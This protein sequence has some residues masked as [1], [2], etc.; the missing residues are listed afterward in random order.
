MMNTPSRI[1]SRVYECRWAEEGPP[2][3]ADLGTEFWEAAQWQAISTQWNGEAVDP[4]WE[5]SFAARWTEDF[6]YF[7]FHSRFQNLTMVDRPLVQTRTPSLWDKE[8]VVEIFIA[9]DLKRP[10]RY[11][12]FELSPSA[13]WIEIDLDWDRNLKNFNW[14]AGMESRST[15]NMVR[16]QWQ[17]EFRVPLG[18][19]EMKGVA[20]GTCVALNA[21]RVELRSCLYLAWNPTMTPKPDFHV[22]QRF[23]QMF[24][25]Q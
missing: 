25:S 11:K 8:D 15:V 13:Q 10:N 24:L 14:A 23:G 6:L 21:Y 12:E 20:A 4:Q 18:S 5:T 3:T 7:G 1:P 9:P 17:A 16:R 19:L 2:L 22:P